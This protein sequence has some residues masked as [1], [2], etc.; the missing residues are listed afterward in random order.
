MWRGRLGCDPCAGL[1]PSCVQVFSS[2]RYTFLYRTRVL[3]LS[4]T[5]RV[6]GNEDPAFTELQAHG[7]TC[8]CVRRWWRRAEGRGRGS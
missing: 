1:W 2:L 7:A 6:G 3:R 8:V 4:Q 5:A